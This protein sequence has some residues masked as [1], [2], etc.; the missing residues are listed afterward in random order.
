MGSYC[1]LLQQF[2]P[3]LASVIDKSPKLTLNRAEVHFCSS[4]V[5][6]M[7]EIGRSS[8]SL[9]HIIIQRLRLLEA[10]PQRIYLKS[11]WVS[12]SSFNYRE[13]CRGEG[14]SK[15]EIERIIPVVL[16]GLFPEWHTLLLPPVHLPNG[17][18]YLKGKLGN[19]DVCPGGKINVLW[20]AIW[21]DSPTPASL[22]RGGNLDSRRF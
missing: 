14:E 15:A 3:T 5:Q 20:I 22:F 7:V 21:S 6:M 13:S 1:Y 8:V 4:K 12:T 19:T 17:H 2:K 10:L 16:Y 11:P 9:L 18:T